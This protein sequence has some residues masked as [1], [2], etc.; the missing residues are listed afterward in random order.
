MA[1][2]GHLVSEH[3]FRHS[4][5]H[6]WRCR[7]PVIFRSTAQWFISMDRED[8]RGQ[9]LQEISKVQWLPSWGRERIHNM[10]S[11]R[12]D[13]CIS[14]QRTW[15]V[16]IIAF[17]CK[18]CGKVL[19]DS[20]LIEH[21]ARIFDR[22]GADA[23]YR[24]PV[25]ELLPAG[26]RCACGSEE[27]HK[28]DDIL[29]VWFD[30]GVSHHVL[31]STPGLAW[32]ADLYLEGGDQFRGWF[33]SSLLVGVGVGGG[34]PY[35]SVLCHGWTLDAEGKAMSK[36][37]GNVISPQKITKRDG[38]EILRLWVSSIDYTEDVRL[39]EEIL[40]RLRDAYR[41][42]RNT[43][44]F[45]L[46]NLH[47]FTPELAVPDGKLL[48][49][50]RWALAQTSATA[51]RVEEAYRK[52][53]FHTVYH[54]LY[55]FCVVELSSFY[56]DVLKD[57]LYVSA[58]DSME[59]RSAQTALFRIADAL[60][61]LLAPI[62]PFTTTQIW[63]ELYGQNPP[64]ESVHMV[65]FSRELDRYADP[66]LLERWAPLLEIRHQVSK[67]LE[68]SRQEKLIGNSLEAA[69]RIKAGV[70]VLENLRRF[71][72]DLASIFI[73][74]EV[75]LEPGQDLASDGIE[76]HVSRTRAEKC[77]R[78]WNHRHSVGTHPD[79]PNVCSR[80]RT[81]LEQIGALC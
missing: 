43:S 14:R 49:M 32:P 37:R 1:R 28:D 78:C 23:W 20:G 38:A 34:A 67:A 56:L 53:E 59:R 55:N 46:G 4:Y 58:A 79:L 48:E 81:V 47:D 69:V 27:F 72:A 44:R 9:S 75:E 42:L 22:E 17:Y 3:P 11:T 16:P 64:A 6:C 40:S 5:P 76:I 73:V 74:S 26:T 52:F 7:N 10:I 12:P 19:L 57:R 30:S 8:L 70:D 24:R 36:S 29:D 45:L 71:S 21:V 41:K 18:G 2:E 65:E 15:G 66:E 80:C 62:L 13:W 35:R 51:R 61:R 63:E 77:R 50:D 54:S 25:S 33:H 39:G 31:R 60:V 68:E